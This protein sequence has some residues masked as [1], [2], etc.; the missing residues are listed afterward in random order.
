MD[1][2]AKDK[3]TVRHG[4]ELINLRVPLPHLQRL[5]DYAKRL[6]ISRS[7]LLL[8]GA[9]RLIELEQQEGHDVHTVK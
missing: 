7:R 1:S 8:T 9:L 4:S 3:T 5:N 6:G 2:I